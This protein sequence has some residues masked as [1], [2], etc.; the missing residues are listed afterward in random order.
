MHVTDNITE[1]AQQRVVIENLRPRVEDG[2]YPAKVVSGWPVRVSADIFSDGHEVIAAAVVLDDGTEARMR[3][4]DN[5]MWGADVRFGKPGPARFHVVAW[6]DVFATW[7]RDTLKKLGAQQDV[8]VELQ[9]L[10]IML[11]GMKARRG[12]GDRIKA[13]RNAARRAD[14]DTILSEETRDYMAANGP[15][16]SLTRT[17]GQEVR[18]SRERAA[19]S[20]WY[21]LFPR[22]IGPGDRHGT[23]RDVIDHLPYVA[24]MGFDVLYF[25]PIH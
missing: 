15:R 2:D 23:F 7:R 12:E 10:S 13:L 11:A 19:F 21:E 8:S 5:D 9:E 14:M 16:A 3:H 24:G 1:L 20:A 22:S 4:I 18:V 6:R 17:R 25:P